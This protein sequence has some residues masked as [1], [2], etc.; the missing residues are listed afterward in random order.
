M[1]TGRLPIQ[2]VIDMLERDIEDLDRHRRRLVD[3][4][5]LLR[6]RTG[7]LPHDMQGTEKA[8][9]DALASAAPRAPETPAE[10]NS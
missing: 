3:A 9:G 8:V 1:K 6:D 10:G 2:D 5:N 4:V 7:S